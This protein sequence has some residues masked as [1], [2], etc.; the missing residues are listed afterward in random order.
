MCQGLHG[1]GN[2]LCEWFTE[3]IK[4]KPHYRPPQCK[5]LKETRLEQ[6]T[7]IIVSLKYSRERLLTFLLY[8]SWKKC[9]PWYCL[10]T[11][12]MCCGN[13]HHPP[14][15][16]H[17]ESILP[18]HSSTH[19]HGD[20]SSGGR[21]HAGPPPIVITL[22]SINR[23]IPPFESCG[24]SLDLLCSRVDSMSRVA[25]NECAIWPFNRIWAFMDYA[26]SRPRLSL[27]E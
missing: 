11:Q 24:R 25:F 27:V 18:H 15:R 13:N 14:L 26:V 12:E 4:S 6:S 17:A 1:R 20:S 5:W 2:E 10:V 19:F 9:D 8:Q 7:Y 22:R 16:T 21:L 23:L 3:S